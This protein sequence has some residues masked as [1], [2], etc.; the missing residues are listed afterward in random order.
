M[1]GLLQLVARLALCGILTALIWWLGGGFSPAAVPLVL[2]L[3]VPFIGLVWIILL[4]RPLADWFGER[5]GRLF[6]SDAGVEVQP[7]YSLAEAR[8]KHGEYPE[9]IE[10]Y[11]DYIVKYPKEMLPHMRIADIQLDHFSNAGAAM[12][13]IRLGLA[14]AQTAQAFAVANFRLAELYM[15]HRNDAAAA[16]ECLQDVQRRFPGTKQ[17]QAAIQRAQRL[18]AEVSPGTDSA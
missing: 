17:A 2:F 10:A 13:E 6:W 8:A 3:L 7:Q 9:A 15:R 1:G 18:I 4:A 16:L 14:K 12:E 11:R 5:A